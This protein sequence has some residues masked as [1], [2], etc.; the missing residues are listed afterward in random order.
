MLHRSATLAL[1]APRRVVALVALVMAAAAIFGIPAANSLS[2]GGFED[3]DSESARAGEL[4]RDTFGRSDMQLII[5]VTGAA[6]STTTRDTAVTVSR[7][8]DTSPDVLSVVSPRTGVI[9]AEIDGDD[10]DAPEHARQLADSIDSAL[11]PLPPDVT[12]RAGGSALV[13]AQINEQTQR[14]LVMMELVALP[15]S[16]VVLVWVFGGLLAATVPIAVGALCIVASMAVLRLLALVTDVSV[17]ALNL[18]TALGFALA[19]DYTLLIVSR[20]RDELADGQTP[21]RALVRTMATAGHTVIFSAVTVV[22][23]MA[24]MALFPMQVLKSL[25]YAGVATVFFAALAAIVVTP[26]ALVLLGPRL[27]RFDVRTPV[28]RAL[29]LNPAAPGRVGDRFWYRSARFA[30][31]HAIVLGITA[32]AV[33]MLVGAPFA[34][35]RWGFPDDR[36]LPASASAHQ[37][38]DQLRTESPISNPVTVVITE[39]RGITPAD[40]DRY[41]VDLSLVPDV[42][43]VTTTT[44]TFVTGVRAGPP[45]APAGESADS[46]YLTVD[47]TAPLFSEASERQLDRLHAVVGP[48]G[49]TVELAGVAQVNRDSVAAI[50]AHLPW[51]LGLIA[52]VT[53]TLLFL[54]TG[55]VVL[56][57]KALVLNVLSLSA[58]F[59]ALVW[60]FQDGHL[61]ALG[62]TSTGTL[63]ANIP[64]LL[65]CIAFGLS[66]DYEVFLVSRIREFWLASGRTRADNDE[67]VALGLAH[68]G[69]VITAAALL[70]SISFAAL[71]T[72]EVSFLRMFGL[73]LT[74]AVLVDATLVRMIL[75]PV[76]IHLLGRWNW[77][78]PT[79]LMTLRRRLGMGDEARAPGPGTITP[80]TQ[81]ISR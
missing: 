60:I 49:R 39:A 8:L 18:C 36:V 20:Y 79:S 52:V 5:T 14:D 80:N 25:A 66:M 54:L 16:S 24:A 7:L 27:D 75:V 29:R 6:D 68:T 67:S 41:A 9:I 63:V 40:V 70:M 76:F 50:T 17:L 22:L 61:G 15:V 11:D 69:R 57:V 64:V 81:R 62:T 65:F 37:V 45:A 4:L 56:P 72:A 48:A 33:L 34:G 43:A 23:S 2:S 1:T 73:G 10:T 77:W 44:A 19:I 13:Y 71:T 30:M 35:V 26:A 58:T 53:L 38:G 59:G 55:S 47:S 78:A 28:R 3:P 32:V 31:R 21:Q 12:V 74:V 51:V 42:A 46:V